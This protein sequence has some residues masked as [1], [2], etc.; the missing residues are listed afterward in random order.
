MPGVKVSEIGGTTLS[1]LDLEKGYYRTSADSKNI[2][3]CLREEACVGGVD[4]SNYCASGY[5]GPCTMNHQAANT[6]VPLV[7]EIVDLAVHPFWL[8]SKGEQTYPILFSSANH[9]KD[10]TRKINRDVHCSVAYRHL[11]L[12]AHRSGRLRG[13]QITARNAEKCARP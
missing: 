2:L 11:V 6:F 13:I 7:V 5:Q 12:W 1:T 9:A 8:T 10:K 4:S 3:K